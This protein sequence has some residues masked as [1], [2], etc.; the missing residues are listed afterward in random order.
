MKQKQIKHDQIL[1]TYCNF[2]GQSIINLIS[3][4]K[5]WIED[6]SQRGFDNLRLVQ[7]YSVNRGYYNL[8]GDRMETEDEHEK[9]V[10]HKEAAAKRYKM[11]K[12]K[13]KLKMEERECKEYERLK[14]K[15]EK[16]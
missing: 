3:T 9:R 15:F 5:V 10:K 12:E 14:A 2:D 1:K 13:N 7:D 8:I 16:E 4:L 11:L 6:S